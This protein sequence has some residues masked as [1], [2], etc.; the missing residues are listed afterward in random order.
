MRNKYIAAVAAQVAGLASIVAAAA[1]VAP[2][3][4]FAAAGVELV[5][6][7]VAQERKQRAG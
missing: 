7:G 1:L 6:V 5:V 3:W 4:G 2:A